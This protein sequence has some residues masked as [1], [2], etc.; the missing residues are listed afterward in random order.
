MIAEG[1]L[2][3]AA[4]AVAGVQVNEADSGNW[5]FVGDLGAFNKALEDILN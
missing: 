2:N 1:K 4:K 5:G 3:E